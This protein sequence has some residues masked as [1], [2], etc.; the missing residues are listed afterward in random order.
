LSFKIQAFVPL[1]QAIDELKNPDKFKKALLTELQTIFLKKIKKNAPR[2]TGS[3]SQSWKAGEV[4]ASKATV[5]TPQGELYDILEF[6]GRTPGRIDASPGSVLAFVWNGADT[7][8]AFVNNPGF[9]EMPHVRPALRETMKEYPQIF[10]KL[11]KK[12]FKLF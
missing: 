9:E 12:H 3:Y 10:N 2:K 7:F 5:E 1:N 6:Q 11:F 8:L 4:T